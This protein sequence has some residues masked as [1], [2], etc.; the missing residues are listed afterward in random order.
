MGRWWLPPEI[1]ISNGKQND[2]FRHQIGLCLLELRMSK[3][4]FIC[5]TEWWHLQVMTSVRIG[6][7]QIHTWEQGGKHTQKHTKKLSIQTWLKITSVTDLWRKYLCSCKCGP[8]LGAEF[9]QQVQETHAIP[10]PCCVHQRLSRLMPFAFFQKRVMWGEHDDSGKNSG[11]V[12]QDTNH[13]KK[14]E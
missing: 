12:R 11:S 8:L 9:R 4:L 5:R 13:H 7:S 3:A 2:A 6:P 14:W 1:T 10:N